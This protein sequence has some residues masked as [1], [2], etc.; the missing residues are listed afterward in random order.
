MRWKHVSYVEISHKKSFLHLHEADSKYS[1]F[2]LEFLKSRCDIKIQSSREMQLYILY[3]LRDLPKLCT[4][5]PEMREFPETMANVR[6]Q[7]KESSQTDGCNGET[8][9]L[10]NR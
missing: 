7:I 10:Q 2:E 3:I 1:N 4:E 8:K 9:P 6:M 5:L